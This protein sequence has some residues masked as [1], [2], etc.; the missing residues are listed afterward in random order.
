MF[1][2]ITSYYRGI[3]EIK[4]KALVNRKRFAQI[5][6]DKTRSVFPFYF[7]L[8]ILKQK[9][10]KIIQMAVNFIGLINKTRSG[11]GKYICYYSKR[12]F[13]WQFQWIWVND[14]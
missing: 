8:M 10:F 7:F 2:R 14:F 5:Q 11:K 13:G 3:N 9:L 4:G 1:F 6:R 12:I